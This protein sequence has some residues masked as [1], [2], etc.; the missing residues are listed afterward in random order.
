[1]NHSRAWKST[2][3][4]ALVAL[5]LV[6]ATALVTVLVTERQPVDTIVT[7][8]QN[9]RVAVIGDSYSSG[10]DNAVVWPSLVAQSSALS[11]V[12]FAIPG[13]GYVG[14]TGESGPFSNQLDR[15]V[16]AK[17]D[18]VVVFGG[19]NDVGK[20]VELIR[21]AATDL[22]AELVRRLPASQVI[23]L[24]PLWHEEPPPE[25]ALL[26]DG[27]VSAAA[28][29]ANTPYVRL[30]DEKWLVP[31]GLVQADGIHPTDMGQSAMARE[32]GPI[33]QREIRQPGKE[34]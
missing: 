13:A 28:D 25:A 26:I 19:I 30:I 33:L 23:V 22:L 4:T 29:E 17:P 1:M 20:S 6:A 9:T 31:P 15:A 24:G 16:A 5:L 2:L 34:S 7:A 11:M 21:Q 14:G 8:D 12:N 10:S 18:V 3:A 27:A 32:I